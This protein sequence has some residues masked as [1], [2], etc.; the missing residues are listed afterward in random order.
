MWLIN[1]YGG[2]G[3]VKVLQSTTNNKKN[4]ISNNRERVAAE[5]IVTELQYQRHS[6]EL[7]TAAPMKVK[8]LAMT[9]QSYAI[10]L[11]LSHDIHV[12]I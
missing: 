2:K 12:Q 4:L 10:L 7:P 5:L 9:Q 3:Y 11:I 1:V 6:V 8:S